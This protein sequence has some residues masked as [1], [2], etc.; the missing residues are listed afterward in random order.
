LTFLA[1]VMASAWF[2]G[3]A[4]AAFAMVLSALL[5]D[6]YF[7]P[8][9][10]S[11]TLNAADLGTIGFFAVEALTVAYCI[12]YLRR[13]ERKLRQVNVDLEQEVGRQALELSEREEKLRGLMYQLAITEER[14][15]RELSV[16]LHDY[17][18]QLLALARMKMKQAQQFVLRSRADA[19]CRIVEAEDL[20]HKSIDYVRT[21]MAE[22]YP[23]QLQDLG[24]P[25]AVR[26]LAAQMPRH[27]LDIELS[28]TSESLP[29][30]S[31]QALVLYQSV[32][33]LLMNIVKHAQ[34]SRAVVT[35]ES[36]SECIFITVKDQGRGFDPSALTARTD[37][38][39]FGLHSVHERINAMGGTFILNS[40]V[41]K[42]TTI[43]LTLPYHHYSESEVLRAASSMQQDRVKAVPTA[44][45]NQQSLP[46]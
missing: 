41:G 17:L 19:Y 29:L 35:L 15:R 24:L 45:Q 28:L 34:V 22:L 23:T 7:I 42:G 36:D 13:N 39:H 1:A 3:F 44:P 32:R 46:S 25:G 2:G 4:S 27:G 10:H 18:A 6:F 16:E 8:P 5:I 12:D 37:G 40:T 14:E 43:K 11:F 26:W 21:L 9:L 30:S 38:R 31:D 20:L 33:E